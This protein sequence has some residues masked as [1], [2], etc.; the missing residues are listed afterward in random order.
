MSDELFEHL[1]AIDAE[2]LSAKET[3]FA[4]LDKW[5][6]KTGLLESFYDVA[7]LK[8]LRDQLSQLTRYRSEF[9]TSTDNRIPNIEENYILCLDDAILS[10][11]AD[12]TSQGHGRNFHFGIPIPLPEGKTRPNEVMSIALEQL[13]CL[14]HILKKHKYL[15]LPS[16]LEGVRRAA[17]YFI[18]GKMDAEKEVTSAQDEIELSL[19]GYFSTKDTNLKS[20]YSAETQAAFSAAGAR[21]LRNISALTTLSDRNSPFSRLRKPFAIGN[22]RPVDAVD[23]EKLAVSDAEKGHINNSIRDL[24]RSS[25]FTELKRIVGKHFG[26]YL[27]RVNRDQSKGGLENDREIESISWIV[28]INTILSKS[29]TSSTKRAV[30]VSSSPRV[31][32]F[33][34][35]F[36]RSSLYKPHQLHPKFLSAYELNH[37]RDDID[38][39]A[40]V[41]WNQS[42]SSLRQVLTNGAQYVL[43]KDV[44]SEKKLNEIQQLLTEQA[45]VWAHF[46][47]AVLEDWRASWQEEDDFFTSLWG[48]I[49]AESEGQSDYSGISKSILA[50][51][52]NAK[53]LENEATDLDF[54]NSRSIEQATASFIVSIFPP[55]DTLVKVSVVPD[56]SGNKKRAVL[57]FVSGKMRY[58]LRVSD[59]AAAASLEGRNDLTYAELDTFL[60]SKEVFGDDVL[61]TSSLSTLINATSHG[62]WSTV[63]ATT[64]KLIHSSKVDGKP[65]D[66]IL[67]ELYFLRQL[68]ERAIASDS[69]RGTNQR[70]RSLKSA[71][72]TI[73]EAGCIRGTG[74][75]FRMARV[76]FLLEHCSFSRAGRLQTAFPVDMSLAFPCEKKWTDPISSS[77]LDRSFGRPILSDLTIGDQVSRPLE[78]FVALL[79][80]CV[81]ILRTLERGFIMGP[82]QFYHDYA[83]SRVAEMILTIYICYRF[84][85]LQSLMISTDMRDRIRDIHWKSSSSTDAKELKD[86]VECCYTRVSEFRSEAT[87]ASVSSHFS[88]V[89]LRSVDS[90]RILDSRGLDDLDFWTS[91]LQKLVDLRSTIGTGCSELSV[92]GFPRRVAREVKRLLASE[93]ARALSTRQQEFEAKASERHLLAP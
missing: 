53:A 71:W 15:L 77:L 63:L 58:A 64:E 86:I 91:D 14:A 26:E 13:Q 42:L 73:S 82:R 7:H 25:S 60:R 31:H 90:V 67:R 20:D 44:P 38:K 74:M 8:M 75:R 3:I 12:F 48:S 50:M 89:L 35:S 69:S 51:F 57:N 29:S 21:L 46:K 6:A 22:I 83:M 56:A 17:D 62:L 9:A 81:S 36:A 61:W 88:H 85:I 34:S 32:A 27:L 19:E 93:I 30:F 54:Q 47:G 59:D 16:N 39:D 87:D 72:A 41:E 40:L 92:F 23:L 55:N 65:K 45:R 70:I 49:Q 68:A 2:F 10:A 37:F 79:D 76:G 1:D 52:D 84:Q 11:F 5:Q 80:E 4:E 43:E 33:L 78:F 66:W 28:A 24:K 18:K